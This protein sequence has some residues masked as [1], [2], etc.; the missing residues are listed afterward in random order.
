MQRD[1]KNNSWVSALMTGLIIV[2]VLGVF[3]KSQ[4]AG[5]LKPKN[6]GAD[7]ISIKKHAVSVVLNNGYARTEVDQIFTSQAEQD[8]E[9]VYSFPLPR[10]AS[11]SEL[12]LWIDG[13]EVIGEVLE[14]KKAQDIY[15][16]QK[17]AGKDTALA[18]KDDYKTFDV[19]VYPV[20]A[21]QDTRVRLVYYQ[22]LRIDLNI[23]RYVYPLQEGGTDEERLAFW[24]VDDQ[25]DEEFSFDLVFKSAHPV[26]DVRLPGYMQQAL[27]EQLPVDVGEE[28]GNG[29]VYHARIDSKEGAR[30]SEDI[31]FYYRLD[32][33][34]PGRVELVPYRQA[35]AAAGTFMLTITPAASL[36]EITEGTDWVFILDRSGS[37]SGDKLTT[38]ADGVGKVLSK[39][40]AA[41]RFRVVT[42]NNRVHELTSGFIEASEG[43]VQQTIS[44]LKGVTAE[45]GTAL[46]DGLKS[47]LRRM[48][49]ERTTAIVLV[50][51]GVANVGPTAQAEFLKLVDEQDV[52]LFTFIMG[53]S[54]NRPLLE[55]LAK[56][57]GG[58]AMDISPRDD[59][60]GRIL[61]AKNKVFYQ[62]LHDAHINFKGGGM[63]DLTPT[64]IG[65][66]YRGQQLVV[67]G[68]YTS[69]GPVQITLDA[70]VSG[71]KQEWTCETILPDSDTDNPEIER[72]WAL[73]RIEQNMETIRNIGETDALVQE[74]VGIGK[75][76]SLVTDYTSMLVLDEQEMENLGLERKNS[77]R[78]QR[79]RQAMETREAQP[80]RSYRADQDG[81]GGMFKGLPSP[82]VGSGPVGPWMIV[83][84]LVCGW[85]VRRSGG[86]N[87]SV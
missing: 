9:A 66:L 80:V 10:E 29:T 51:D 75:E 23:G 41:D 44:Q 20:R 49:D 72:L 67:F 56:A 26:K 2:L 17:S 8:L 83:L 1:A 36:A 60:Y 76:Y 38:L 81:S 21:G 65:S 84:L 58:F 42:F 13:K 24:S 74:I 77:A 78:V 43:N 14:K 16:Q 15:Q 50:T 61:Q 33:T 6:G 7:Q 18:E 19:A 27:V 64:D 71:E 35:G 87:R 57:S 54:S 79:E 5:L 86:Y 40:S 70:K 4:A 85:I 68:K 52:R 31:V 53:N 11:L 39:M 63:T 45:G 73:A 47:G 69:P 3:G 22:P 62:A 34:V 46:Y 48:D 25:V 32:D 59:I 37:M 55:G 30:L 82:G 28:H 12:S